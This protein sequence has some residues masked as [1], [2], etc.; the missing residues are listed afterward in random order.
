M[1]C[2]FKN[3]SAVLFSLIIFSGIALA[4]VEK[5]LMDG[6]EFYFLACVKEGSAIWEEPS[7]ASKEIRKATW[8]EYFIT[9]KIKTD[10]QD[11]KWYRVGKH[12]SLDEADAVGW[13]QKKDLLVT[14]TATKKNGIYQKAIVVV[15]YD[16]NKKLIAGAPI[17]HIPK[18]KAPSVGQDLTLL[19]IYYIYDKQEE[20]KAD[21]T[22]FLL[23]DEPEIINPLK[24]GDSIVGWVSKSRLFQ[25]DTREAA[26]YDK[27]TISKLKRKPVII[28]ENEEELKDLILGKKTSEQIEPLATES[29]QKETLYPSDPRFPIIT[30]ERDVNGVKMWNIGFVG[31]EVEGGPG[32]RKR[33]EVATLSR[34][35]NVVDILFVYDGTGSMKK[36]KDSVIEAVKQAKQA[37]VDYWKQNFP[38]ES[39]ADLRFSIAMYKDYSESDYYRRE[40]LQDDKDNKI[41]DFITKHKFSGGD[42][43]P[44]V[45]NGISSALKD[46]AG[47][48]RKESFRAVILIG[49]MGNM[50]K[51]NDPD[52]KGHN[53]DKIVGQLKANQCD[54][55]AIHVASGFNHK[56]L[57]KFENEA[58]TIAERLD[59][60]TSEY[61]PMKDPKKVK[62]EIYDKVMD[63]LDQRYRLPQMLKNISK[64]RKLL[65][66]QISGTILEKRAIDIMKRHGLNPD[67]FATKGV[68]AFAKGW[69][70]PKEPGTGNRAMKPVV[71]MNKYEVETLIAILGRI[72]RVKIENVKKG[73]MQ[74]FEEVTGDDIDIDP[75]KGVPADIIKIHLGIPVRSGILNKSFTE[76][77]KLTTTEI[78]EAVKDFKKKL[79]LLRAVVNEKDIELKEDDKGDITYVRKGDKKYWFGTRGSER[80]W[81]DMEVFLP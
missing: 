22:F 8:M 11:R 69:V 41:G 68:A 9:I 35:S 52:P 23:G 26:E 2:F 32:S 40:G 63:L 73:W 28:Y 10:D 58:K 65:G 49:D 75:E 53:I 47:E 48:M 16:Q 30:K 24:P 12:I 1:F 17:R 55:Y 15:H 76:I 50:G 31:D 70:A 51:S 36:Y 78:T 61:I 56:A 72:S 33:E 19:N 3:V 4:T 59:E 64:G 5:P 81:L 45:F 7:I 44:A 34:M 66:K 14:Q 13:M 43:M 39:L 77:G 62:A 18:T 74:A 80:V 21:E 29:I 79:F 60:G 27:A 54:F 25:W 6:D 42:D 57:L 20:I 46:G 71:L 38:G 37:S 67:D